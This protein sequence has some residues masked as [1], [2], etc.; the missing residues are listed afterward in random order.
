MQAFAA[1]PTLEGPVPPTTSRV[2]RLVEHI[3]PQPKREKHLQRVINVYIDI[4]GIKANVLLDSGSTTNMMSPEFAQV[5]DVKTIELSERMGLQLAVK[6]SS[7]KLNYGAWAQITWGPI[8]QNNYFDI[9]NI[10]RYDVVLGTPFFWENHISLIFDE[11]CRV[12]TRGRELRIPQA[13]THPS[14]AG[15]KHSFRS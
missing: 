3:A 11:N 1:K 13:S 14:G 10:D 12:L 2:R 15:R 7:S 8:S 4:E 6:G 9:V 5:A